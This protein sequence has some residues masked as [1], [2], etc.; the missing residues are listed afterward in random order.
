MAVTKYL[1]R[2]LTIAIDTGDVVG[3]LGTLTTPFGEADT[4]VLTDTAHGLIAGQRIRFATLTG[5]TGLVVGTDYY[6]ISDGLTADNFKV[7]DEAGGLPVNF[8][9]DITAGTYNLMEETWTTIN[10]LN[11]L[12]HSPATTRADTTSFDS[13]GRDE[14][15]PA[16]RGES[17]SLSGFSLED[18]ATGTRDPGQAAVEALG[19]L[20]GPAGLGYFR[21][22]SPGGN[23]ITFLA[24][25]EVTIHGGGHNDAAAWGAEVTVSGEPIY[26]A[27]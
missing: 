10:G 23:T 24:S 17:W 27:A 5:G 21:I 8:T 19:K 4:D 11:T 2:D 13:N 7:S 26:Q 6:V 14:H 18:V 15:L 1:A 25:A 3:A 16:S 20:V 22:T 9:T 12:S